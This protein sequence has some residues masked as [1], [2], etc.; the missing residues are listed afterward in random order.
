MDSLRRF[1]LLLYSL[2]SIAELHHSVRTTRLRGASKAGSTDEVF[3]HL[4][5]QGNTPDQIYEAVVNQRVE[6]VLTAHPTQVNR[7]TLQHK[8]TRIAQLLDE[9]DRETQ[10]DYEQVSLISLCM[11]LF[12]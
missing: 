5:E 9:K 8:L 7:R 2:T 1:C 6:I 3:F 10:S 4:Q 12:P 11:P